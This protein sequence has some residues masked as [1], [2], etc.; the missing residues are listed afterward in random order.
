MKNWHIKYFFISL[1]V[2][3]IFPGN[4][5]SHTVNVIPKQVNILNH[6]RFFEYLKRLPAVLSGFQRAV[7]LRIACR[8]LWDLTWPEG[9]ALEAPYRS[10]LP[11][12]NQEMLLKELYT[13]SRLI[14]AINPLRG[15]KTRPLSPMGQ[16][17]ER[18]IIRI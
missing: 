6:F 8:W 15:P 11:F 18:Y 10:E 12:T 9:W 5:K 16:G 1:V 13:Y 14:P 17:C 2:F 4:T 7:R 3:S